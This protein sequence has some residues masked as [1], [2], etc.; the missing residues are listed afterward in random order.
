MNTAPAGDGRR[1]DGSSPATAEAEPVKYESAKGCLMMLVATI[2][3][4]IA[5][6]LVVVLFGDFSRV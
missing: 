1:S 3:C 5:I 2:A 4:A 6:V